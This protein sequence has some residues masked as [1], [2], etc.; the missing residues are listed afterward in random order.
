LILSFAVLF[1][2]WRDRK[3]AGPARLPNSAVVAG[4]LIL[5]IG[6]GAFASNLGRAQDI[7][8][9]LPG[10]YAYLSD[11]SLESYYIPRGVELPRLRN[12]EKLCRS[13]SII[14]GNDRVEIEGNEIGTYDLVAKQ[15]GGN[16]RLLEHLGN[17]KKNFHQLHPYQDF[18]GKLVVMGDADSPSGVIEKV[19][20]T[21][22]LGE[23]RNIQIASVS[24]NTVSTAVF[25]E[26]RIPRF[27]GVPLVLIRDE[28][29]GSLRI[30]SDETFGEFA[31]R[32]DKAAGSGTVKVLLPGDG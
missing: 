20:M 3:M 19:L 23:Y 11:T 21:C 28:E 7:I 4:V 32:V 14:V 13:A 12:V 22:Y 15:E 6:G 8:G 9:S 17:L 27:F 24:I 16:P 29:Q 25:G 30:Q 2:L 18:P 10:L 31:K 5:A 26:I 1:A